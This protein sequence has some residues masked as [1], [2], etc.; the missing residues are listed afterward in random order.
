[1]END[2][3][4]EQIRTV[5]EMNPHSKE[6]QVLFADRSVDWVTNVA[7]AHPKVRAFRAQ[8]SVNIEVYSTESAAWMHPPWVNID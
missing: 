5:M 3:R 7:D 8:N 2:R 1:M 4:L 6:Y